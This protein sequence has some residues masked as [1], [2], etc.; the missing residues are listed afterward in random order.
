MYGHF[1]TVSL[2]LQNFV[3]D[4]LISAAGHVIDRAVHFFDADDFK[5]PGGFTYVASYNAQLQ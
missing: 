5:L 3:Q 4:I 2:L 1:A